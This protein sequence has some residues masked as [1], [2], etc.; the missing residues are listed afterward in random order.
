MDVNEQDEEGRKRNKKEAIDPWWVSKCDEDACDG[1]KEGRRGKVGGRTVNS[2]SWTE[3]LQHILLPLAEADCQRRT[4]A[5]H[6]TL[7]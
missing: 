1:G 4:K 7:L 6:S 5:D 3:E 2:L